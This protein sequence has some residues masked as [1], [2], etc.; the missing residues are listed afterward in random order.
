MYIGIFEFIKQTRYLN[1]KLHKF[2][3]VFFLFSTFMVF[4]QKS[5]IYTNDLVEYNHAIE[6]YQNRDYNAAQILFTKIKNQ[7]D[8]A[9]EL[10]ARCFYYEAFCAIRLGQRDAEKLMGSFFEK[11]RE[12][13]LRPAH[14]P[15]SGTVCGFPAS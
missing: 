14:P 5:K 2:L 10:K 7:F 1:M 12:S 4:S 3:L 15:V 9:S 13:V 11:F 6:L 8:D